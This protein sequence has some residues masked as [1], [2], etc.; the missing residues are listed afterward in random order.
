SVL[1]S[2]LGLFGLAA[3]TTEQ[4]TKEIGI[5]KVMGASVAGITRLLASDFLRLVL[6]AIVIATPVAWYAMKQWLGDFAYRAEI[7]WWIFVL[8]GLG[9]L[10][11]AFLTVSFQSI[12]AALAD[13]VKS[14]RNE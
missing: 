10:V 3:F 9:A 8:A 5:R 1:I 6:A 14:L 7:S 4:R 2:C 12:R 11:I 13:P